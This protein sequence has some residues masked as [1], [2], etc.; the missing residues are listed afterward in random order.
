MKKTI[1]IL[2]V[3]F[4]LGSH[5]RGSDLGPLAISHTGLARSLSEKNYAVLER[6]V[7]ISTEPDKNENPNLLHLKA[8]CDTSEELAKQV[9]SVIERGHFPLVLGGDHSIALGTIAGVTTHY[10]NVGVLWIDAHGDAN[11]DETSP[12]GNIH[13]MPLAASLGYGHPLLTN[14]YGSVLPKVKPKN[15]ALIGVRDLDEGEVEF[16]KQHDIT[17][18]NMSRVNEIGISIVLQQIKEQFQ[19]ESVKH[20]HLSFDMDVLD[21]ELVPGVGT[22]VPGGMRLTQAEQVIKE[23]KSWNQLVSAEFVEVN[24]L[25]DNKNRT[26]KLAARLIKHLF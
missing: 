12:S 15:V 14:L 21:P 18:Y 23:V 25:L 5:R 7:T 4:A 3:P 9:D 16:F 26:A 6:E 11:T 17:Y 22:P 1:D 2:R 19:H 10:D 8:V 20:I 13:G 24:P